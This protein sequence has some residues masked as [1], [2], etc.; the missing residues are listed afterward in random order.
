MHHGLFIE[1]MLLFWY[2]KYDTANGFSQRNI[3]SHQFLLLIYPMTWSCRGFIKYKR[4]TAM[5]RS[6]EKRVKDW[7]EIYNMDSVRRGLRVQAARCMECGVP[8]CQSSHGC[9][10]GNIIPKWN[11]LIFN[12][13]W[14]EALNQLLQTNNFPGTS[15]IPTLI[16]L[17][18]DSKHKS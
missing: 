11:D 13:N 1:Y 2:H 4:E 6:A 18:K 10:L 3:S 7:D 17:M 9:P 5:Y 14:K 16:L 12:N 8:F 15:E